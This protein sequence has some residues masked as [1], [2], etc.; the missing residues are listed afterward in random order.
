VAGV[1]LFELGDMKAAYR[2]LRAMFEESRTRGFAGLDPKYLAFAKG[3][4]PSATA[5]PNEC[6]AK[7]ARPSL[8]ES[9]AGIKALLASGTRLLT[10][11]RAAE[12]VAELARAAEMLPAS[13]HDSELALGLYTVLG[14]A[15]FRVGRWQECAGAVADGMNCGRGFADPYLNLRLGQALFE[16]GQHDRAMHYLCCAYMLRGPGVFDGSDAKYL[17]ALKLVIKE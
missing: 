5:G 13:V 2:R 9:V 16:T 12:A 10:D 7:A 6:A 17:A 3:A 15:Y 4:E 11:G 1:L 8:E 14:D